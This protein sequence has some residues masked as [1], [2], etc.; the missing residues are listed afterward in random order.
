MRLHKINVLIIIFLLAI[1][2]LS[3]PYLAR[4]LSK[5]NNLIGDISYY[6]GRLSQSITEKGAPSSDE[7]SFGGRSYVFN[8]FHNLL[9]FLINM[10]NFILVAKLLPFILGLLSVLMF[11]LILRKLN[12]ELEKIFLICAILILTPIFIYSFTVL[13]SHSLIIFLALLGFYLFMHKPSIC[14]NLNIVIIL[15]FFNC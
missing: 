8:P 2:V 11:Y 9:A 5:N 3:S 4:T 1:I 13:N 15:L 10:F 14:S 7:L 12:L 6:H